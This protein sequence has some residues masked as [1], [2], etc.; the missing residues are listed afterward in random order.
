MFNKCKN[1]HMMTNQNNM[2]EV[3]MEKKPN[4][5]RLALEHDGSLYM[6]LFSPNFVFDDEEFRRMYQMRMHFYG[7]SLGAICNIDT[8]FEDVYLRGPTQSNIIQQV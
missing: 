5:D 7:T 8:Y 4:K 2:E 3:G 6:D 1:H